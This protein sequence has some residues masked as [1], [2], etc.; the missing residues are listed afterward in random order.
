MPRSVVESSRPTK[1]NERE[2]GPRRARRGSTDNTRVD[3]IDS[4]EC[5][6]NRFGTIKERNKD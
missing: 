3:V 6:R 1:T 2:K 5:E 4:N